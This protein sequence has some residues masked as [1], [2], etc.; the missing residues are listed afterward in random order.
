MTQ[1][2]ANSSIFRVT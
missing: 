2:A 1:E